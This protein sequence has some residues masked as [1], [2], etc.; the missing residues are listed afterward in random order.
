MTKKAQRM[1]ATMDRATRLW[2]IP[3][4]GRAKGRVIRRLIDRHRS[5]RAVEI[6]SL[7]GYSAILIA[8]ALAPRGRLTCIETSDYL[9]RM[10]RRNVDEAGLGRKVKVIQGDAVR[11]L[12][13]MPGRFD[14]VFIDAAKED[15]LDYLRQLQP[16]LVAGAVVI[17]DNTGIY[18]KVVA[19]YLE[20]VRG[21]AEY[22]SREYE[23]G[24]DAMEVS[25]F[26][27]P[28]T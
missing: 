7:L 8:G 4:V 3:N 2:H 10:T 23:F 17:A 18:R 9:A 1:L 14:L 13:L 11:L 27:P 5:T 6:G 19:P 26:R 24:D 25:V 21:S 22:A 16:K 20:Y 12:P 28:R 15:Y